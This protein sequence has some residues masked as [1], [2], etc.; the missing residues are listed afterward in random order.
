MPNN[1]FCGVRSPSWRLMKTVFRY[2]M[3]RCSLTQAAVA[4]WIE[5]LRHRAIDIC[6]DYNKASYNLSYKSCI[7]TREWHNWLIFRKPGLIN[8]M[9]YKIYDFGENDANACE[10]KEGKCVCSICLLPLSHIVY[11]M[12]L[13]SRRRPSR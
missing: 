11:L 1:K 10:A 13:A 2:T 6:I 7:S 12:L 3:L 8:I 5:S 4:S 9:Y